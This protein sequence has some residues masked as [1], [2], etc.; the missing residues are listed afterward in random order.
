VVV[1]K[2]AILIISI[3]VY[4]VKVE[5][6][7]STMTTGFRLEPNCNVELG[8]STPRVPRVFRMVVVDG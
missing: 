7:F 3:M 1:V 6:G 2:F 5:S 8:S 4:F